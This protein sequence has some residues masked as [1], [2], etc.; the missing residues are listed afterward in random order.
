M[1][2]RGVIRFQKKI[3]ELAA[4]YSSTASEEERK[5]ARDAYRDFDRESR[6]LT[7]VYSSAFKPDEDT[8]NE[9]IGE[10]C[11]TDEDEEEEEED[12]YD[13]DFVDKDEDDDDDDDE[14]KEDKE[15]SWTNWTNGVNWT[16]GKL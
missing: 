13:S 6:N 16:A 7:R 4:R 8:K 12:G 1:S 15:D 9:D 14:R 10:E 3:E 11:Y 5:T 2:S